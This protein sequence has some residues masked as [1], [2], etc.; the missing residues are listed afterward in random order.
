MSVVWWVVTWGGCTGWLEAQS[1]WAEVHQPDL[2]GP[3]P[4]PIFDAQLCA[5]Q[6]SPWHTLLFQAGVPGGVHGPA[7]SLGSSTLQLG[8]LALTP[9]PWPLMTLS[10]WGRGPASARR[11]ASSWKS[12]RKLAPG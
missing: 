7:G 9:R 4:A 5:G 10:R 11:E 1:C 12:S 8:R 2:C 6:G 3:C